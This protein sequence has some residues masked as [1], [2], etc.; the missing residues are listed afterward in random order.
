L[1]LVLTHLKPSEQ[2]ELR[3]ALQLQEN[4]N[5]I[6]LNRFLHTPIGEEILTQLG[7]VINLPGSQNGKYAIR[8]AAYRAARNQDGLSLINFLR[9]FSTD[10]EL[11]AKNLATIANGVSNLIAETETITAQIQKLSSVEA[12]ADSGVNFANLQ[13][14]RTPGSLGYSKQTI[15]LNDTSRQRQFQVALYRPQQWR[16]GQTPVVIASHGLASSPKHFKKQAQHLASYGY[17][18]AVPQHLGS[19]NKQF[20]DLLSGYS[21]EIFKLNEFIDRP[22]DVTFL[23]NELEK[24]NHSLYKGRLNL[25]EVGV[26]GHSFGGYTALA[27]AGAQIN[28]EQLEIDCGQK[29]WAPN[30]SLLLQCRALDLEKKTYN[31]RD[32]RIKAILA[33]NP[34]NASLFGQ[35][36][37]SQ[38]QI[39]VFLVAGTEDPATPALTEQIR[40]FTWLIGQDKYLTLIKGL[41]HMDSSGSDEGIGAL[42]RSIPALRQR[43]PGVFKNYSNAMVTAFFG[44]YIAHSADYRLY[45]EPSYADYISQP[46]FNMYLLQSS[47]S[48]ALSQ[49]LA[50]F[51]TQSNRDY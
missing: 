28:F 2:A 44:S 48:D 8:S 13:D 17:F 22:L 7:K 50:D 5:P 29:I 41:T 47:S 19:D 6:Q 35:Q 36:S 4:I 34:V 10:V 20:Q 3:K 9:Q 25:N 1:N 27:L 31:F 45:L 15:T 21:Q 49:S 32:S 14:L 24:H 11:N 30:L 46:P 18:V 42:L 26:I 39:P 33:I 16:E 43:Q 40:S 23:L 37:L 38:I 51:R 12:A